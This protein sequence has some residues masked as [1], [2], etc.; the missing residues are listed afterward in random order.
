MWE[1]FQE[2]LRPLVL[3]QHLTQLA[4]SQKQ[5]DR[6]RKIVTLPLLAT[7]AL[8]S[9]WSGQ[10]RHAAA[11]GIS[12]PH[13][14]PSH[15]TT[16]SG[17]PGQDCIRSAEIGMARRSLTVIGQGQ[18]SAPADTALLEF[19]FGNQ[20]PLSAPDT[21]TLEQSI[22][23]QQQRTQNALKPTI[24][25]LTKAGV[26]ERNIT[27]QTR[28]AQAPKLLVTVP[29]PTQERLQQLVLTVEQSLQKNNPLFL[30][31]IGASY[32][33][34]TCQPLERSARRIALRDA[35][36]QLATLAQDVGVTLGELLS[37][38][39]L[40]ISGPANT[41][42]CGTKVGVPLSPLSFSADETTPPYDPS[43]P[44]EVQIR[45]QVSVT[46]AIQPTTPQ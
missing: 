43:D 42:N 18:V 39:V 24:E 32:A 10:T 8:I 17:M 12:E 15:Q 13:C 44:P 35:Q 45:S 29:K 28:S 38:T 30:Q 22:A 40:P 6:M 2:L 4:H 1:L 26:P 34:N 23:R 7:L 14:P 31:G 46:H 25:A 9:C 3:G 41:S 37:V 27:A 5:F 21:A 16:A 33:V 20:E 36:S 19:R 11:Q